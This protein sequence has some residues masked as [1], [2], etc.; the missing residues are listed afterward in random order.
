MT[1]DPVHFLGLVLCH[2]VPKYNTVFQ[3]GG[4]SSRFLLSQSW[5]A[6]RL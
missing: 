3:F 6:K 2:F 1:V 4:L 5:E